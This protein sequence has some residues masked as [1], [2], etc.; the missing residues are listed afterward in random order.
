LLASLSP[1]T[2]GVNFQASGQVSELPITELIGNSDSADVVVVRLH[3]DRIDELERT[4][5]VLENV[6]RSLA[7]VVLHN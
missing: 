6:G 4:I 3:R 5:S 7:G 2:T 1:E